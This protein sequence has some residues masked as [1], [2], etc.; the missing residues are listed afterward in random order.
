MQS[1][2]QEVYL[3]LKTPSNGRPHVV[4]WNDDVSLH[5]HAQ[6]EN[7]LTL[8]D[9]VL[10]GRAV[11]GRQ[12][13]DVTVTMS[14]MIAC[15]NVINSHPT[16]SSRTPAPWWRSLSLRGGRRRRAD[17]RCAAC[18]SR[19][20]ELWWGPWSPGAWSVV[21]WASLIPCY[22]HNLCTCVERRQ[23]HHFLS[24]FHCRCQMHPSLCV[25]MNVVFVTC[26]NH[27][28]TEKSYTYSSCFKSI[29]RSSTQLEEDDNKQH[30]LINLRTWDKVQ[31]YVTATIYINLRLTCTKT[32]AH[33]G[34]L[35][36]KYYSYCLAG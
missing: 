23:D 13:V 33:D 17:S 21:D 36:D 14:D 9:P 34:A 16:S 25:L 2:V 31:N 20:P 30:W 24:R 1:G 29:S 12:K 15:N 22:T 28:Q 10:S 11:G 35:A 26:T 27:S 4:D 8:L 32:L 7:Y 3:G 5:T 18:W 19:G 6:L